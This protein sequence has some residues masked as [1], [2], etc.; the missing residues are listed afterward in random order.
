MNPIMLQR[1]KKNI[2]DN[3]PGIEFHDGLPQLSFLWKKL[4]TF[5][6]G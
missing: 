4:H 1:I 3:H 6:D 2:F 5:G